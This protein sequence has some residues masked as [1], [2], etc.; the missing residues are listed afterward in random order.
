MPFFF[1][2]SKLKAKSQRFWCVISNTQITQNGSSLQS[3]NL[4]TKTINKAILIASVTHAILTGLQLRFSSFVGCKYVLTY[5]SLRG[6][7]NVKISH[8]ATIWRITLLCAADPPYCRASVSPIVSYRLI[9]SS[10]KGQSIPIMGSSV[11]PKACSWC[12][13]ETNP[14]ANWATFVRSKQSMQLVLRTPFWN[15]GGLTK[16]FP[17]LSMLLLV[18]SVSPLTPILVSQRFCTEKSPL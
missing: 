14:N 8:S 7:I 16:R 12:P 15:I 1:H 10:A 13:R 4:L 5:H 2:C 18:S 17:H 6:H 9:K 3:R 11:N